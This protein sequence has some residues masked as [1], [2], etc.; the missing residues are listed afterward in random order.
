MYVIRATLDVATVVPIPI[1]NDCVDGFLGAYWQRPAAYLDARIRSGM[2]SFNR[3]A[4]LNSGLER[5]ARDLRS[6]LWERRYGWLRRKNS[7]DLGYRL[8]V[9]PC[10]AS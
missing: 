6:G 8:V 3:I 4:D 10:G 5:L 1:P 2:S 7:L 9:S